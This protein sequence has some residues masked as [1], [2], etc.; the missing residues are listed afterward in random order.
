MPKPTLNNIIDN[1]KSPCCNA[2]SKAIGSYDYRCLE[3]GTDVTVD[4]YAT[5]K[6][7]VD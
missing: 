5:L 4:F 3:C 2:L 1:Y 7:K 6:H